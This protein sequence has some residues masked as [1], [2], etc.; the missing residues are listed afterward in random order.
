MRGIQARMEP[1]RRRTT[2]P[3]LLAVAACKGCREA[4]PAPRF[5][6]EGIGNPNL[7]ARHPPPA[8]VP[9]L[10]LHLT[11]DCAMGKKKATVRG[12]AGEGLGEP[13]S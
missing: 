11:T 10:T 7:T 9:V 6:V 2:A 3:R 1:V 5:R 4:K 13:N 12:G 8:P